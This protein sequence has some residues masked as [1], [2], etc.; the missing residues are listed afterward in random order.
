MAFHSLSGVSERTRRGA[1]RLVDAGFCDR[2]TARELSGGAGYLGYHAERGLFH[3]AP[4]IQLGP[5]VK[6]PLPEETAPRLSPSPLSTNA[7]FIHLAWVKRY[8]HVHC[9]HISVFLMSATS[10]TNLVAHR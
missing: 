7:T 9:P 1:R 10:C 6:K 4:I 5:G 3:G 2:A 8:L